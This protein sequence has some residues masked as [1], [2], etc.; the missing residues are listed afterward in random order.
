MTFTEKIANKNGGSITISA[1]FLMA[2]LF[3][4]LLGLGGWGLYQI[5]ISK[6]AFATK[7]ELTE[8]VGNVEEAVDRLETIMNNRFKTVDGKLDKIIDELMDI[9]AK[10]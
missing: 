4:V 2:I 6:E 9:C 5:T 1:D 8:H 10:N 7:Q 3:T